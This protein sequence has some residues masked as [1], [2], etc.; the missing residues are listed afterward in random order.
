MDLYI[1]D[2]TEAEEI[3][4][5]G[6]R[7]LFLT[8][9]ACCLGA[10][11]LP[12]TAEA[13]LPVMAKIVVRSFWRWGVRTGT[14]KGDVRV[15][16]KRPK[17]RPK[18]SDGSDL[19]IEFAKE[20]LESAIDIAEASRKIQDQ[21]SSI[22]K[23]PI[24]AKGIEFVLNNIAQTNGVNTFKVW[25]Q[26]GKA[27]SPVDGSV[28]SNKI[29]IRI[30]NNSNRYTERKIQ[31]MLL[32]SYDRKE[33]VKQF[34]VKSSRIESSIFDVSYA[35]VELPATG[36]KEVVY[37]VVGNYRDIVVSSLSPNIL[38]SRLIDG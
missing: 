28:Y 7:R 16:K 14:I 31:L 37:K 32:D 19:G 8:Y 36:V 1:D 3:L 6:D 29:L 15:E 21:V 13:S 25:D 20:S 38:V 24:R 34:T 10:V 22:T 33:H 11:M 2:N 27:V 30:S 35:F 9:S 17:K 26:A 5:I 18:K 12:K 4:N 23:L